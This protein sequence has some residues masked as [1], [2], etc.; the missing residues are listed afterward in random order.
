MSGEDQLEQ[1]AMPVS[2][3]ETLLE[4]TVGTVE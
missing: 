2:N 4:G 1:Q 3:S